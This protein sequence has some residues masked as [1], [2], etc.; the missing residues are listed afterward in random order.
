ME[1]LNLQWLSWL[2][3]FNQF[4]KDWLGNQ[5]VAQ[6]L[7]DTGPCPSQ[8][9]HAGELPT[10]LLTNTWDTLLRKP[11]QGDHSSYVASPVPSRKYAHDSV[12]GQKQRA[13]PDSETEPTVEALS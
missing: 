1:S 2:Y 8:G 11:S 9:N 12:T 5:I 10:T 13:G 4:S 3:T 6:A 7:K